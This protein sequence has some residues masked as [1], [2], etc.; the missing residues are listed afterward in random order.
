[1]GTTRYYPILEDE[2][3]LSLDLDPGEEVCPDCRMVRWK[4]TGPAHCCG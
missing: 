1:M 2:A 3:E 4:A